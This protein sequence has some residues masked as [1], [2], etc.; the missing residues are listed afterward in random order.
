MGGG[1]LMLEGGFNTREGGFNT[2]EGG[3]NTGEGNLAS[4][5]LSTRLI[6]VTCTTR[7]TQLAS[8][9]SIDD[10]DDDDDDYDDDDDDEAGV[11]VETGK[12]SCCQAQPQGCV[13][14]RSTKGLSGTFRHNPHAP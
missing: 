10:D 3:F 1:G 6:W 4:R 5:D 12:V 2:R 13:R 7:L 11:G 8:G 14:S 9:L